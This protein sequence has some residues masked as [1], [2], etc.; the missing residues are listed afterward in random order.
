MYSLPYLV[1]FHCVR[2]HTHSQLPALK[3]ALSSMAVC[4]PQAWTHVYTCVEWAAANRG[5]CQR[6]CVRITECLRH[7][8]LHLPAGDMLSSMQSR[9]CWVQ[10]LTHSKPRHPFYEHCVV[11]LKTAS[12]QRRSLKQQCYIHCVRMSQLHSQHNSM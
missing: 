12:L 8:P 5:L 11:T 9:L 2:M 4:W 7:H 3:V 6:A 1:G 10:A